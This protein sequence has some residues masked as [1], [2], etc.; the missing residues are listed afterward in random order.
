[1]SYNYKKLTELEG[2]TPN[3][4]N[5]HS[6]QYLEYTLLPEQMLPILY[7]PKC[8]TIKASL[9][10]DC[11]SFR[12]PTCKVENKSFYYYYNNKE[13]KLKEGHDP[14]CSARKV[15]ATEEA[16]YFINARNVPSALPKPTTEP[17]TEPTTEPSTEPTTEPL[18][19][20]TTEPLTEPT[21][22]C[23]S[24]T[25]SLT[26]SGLACIPPLEKLSVAEWRAIYP[27]E[28]LLPDKLKNKFLL[29]PSALAKEL[30]NNVRIIA[31]HEWWSSIS[32]DNTEVKDKNR[33]NLLCN[34]EEAKVIV[35]V[36]G[37]F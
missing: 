23:S 32:N 19:E 33:L 21:T 5:T 18:T 20:P 37:F 3:R 26:P 25:S 16:I 30:Y 8:A 9:C 10:S 12:C 27:D 29:Q 35:S 14:S 2:K 6:T 17:S 1:M 34:D 11:G 36:E 13:G 28:T 31:C 24:P 15:Q 4:K 7:C 22:S